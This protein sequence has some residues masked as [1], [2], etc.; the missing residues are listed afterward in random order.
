MNSKNTTQ[1]P[2]YSSTAFPGDAS[3]KIYAS[4]EEAS[5]SISIE[6]NSPCRDVWVGASSTNVYVNGQA[7]VVDNSSVSNLVVSAGDSSSY[8]TT[9]VPIWYSNCHEKA[10]TKYLAYKTLWS[11]SYR[12]ASGS[13]QVSEMRE[14]I[15]LSM[16]M[17]YYN[18]VS[19]YRKHVRV[20]FVPR[21]VNRLRGISTAAPL[22][23][24][25]VSGANP[26]D[27]YDAP[28]Y[29]KS[30]RAQNSNPTL[31]F[32]QPC[33]K[34]A[35]ICYEDDK[36][37]FMN[38]MPFW[39][40]DKKYPI[41][42]KQSVEGMKFGVFGRNTPN[43]KPIVVEYTT[44][45]RSVYG[46]KFDMSENYWHIVAGSWIRVGQPECYINFW[47]TTLE[48]SP[49]SAFIPYIEGQV[50]VETWTDCVFWDRRDVQV[51]FTLPAEVAGSDGTAAVDD[52]NKL[53]LEDED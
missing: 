33:E 17:N 7:Y 44:S 18:K 27:L 16:L 39:L 26:N 34:M 48:N 10:T 43:T 21:Q 3:T 19:V 36:P 30:D 37:E 42:I 4:N 25:G 38:L 50:R 51:S 12:A 46:Q 47:L 20:T 23:G 15:G 28:F 8:T 29:E 6:G 49:D 41:P 13:V 40:E 35:V 45:P 53:E 11:P 24:L 32:G 2:R 22:S 31:A 14:P 52:V 1:Q 9:D 5:L